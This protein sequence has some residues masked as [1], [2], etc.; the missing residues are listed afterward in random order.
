MSRLV[1]VFYN[2]NQI[3]D[4]TKD[5]E[6]QWYQEPKSCY[7]YLQVS[8][9][10]GDFTDGETVTGGTSNATATVFSSYVD[11]GRVYV[12][13][14]SGTFEANETITGS[15]SNQTATVDSFVAERSYPDN[16]I[17][18][19][20][21]DSIISKDIDD[22]LEW[23]STLNGAGNPAKLIITPPT[24]GIYTASHLFGVGNQVGISTS[25]RR[26][27]E[28]ICPASRKVMETGSINQAAYSQFDVVMAYLAS[29]LQGHIVNDGTGLS[30][31]KY[32]FYQSGKG[33]FRWRIH[34][35]RVLKLVI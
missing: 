5:C 31:F 30:I 17:Q 10:S 32:T 35:I 7:A 33:T 9:A 14:V 34:N 6:F 26:V 29:P 15:S 4:V 23:E 19:S 13:D 22:Y 2:Q 1:D 16:I 8:S 24:K 28:S 3:I 11:G 18:G 20:F 21:P 12:T 25:S 27:Y